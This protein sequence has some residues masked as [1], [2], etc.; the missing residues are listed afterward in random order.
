[1]KINPER[2][3]PSLLTTQYLDWS[4]SIPNFNHLMLFTPAVFK[5][6]MEISKFHS[7]HEYFDGQN[8]QPGNLGERGIFLRL[9]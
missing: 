8:L 2:K 4:N 5:Q 3:F 6:S 7:G 9:L 1:M